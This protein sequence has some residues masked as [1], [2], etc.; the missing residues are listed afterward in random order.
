MLVQ[1]FTEIDARCDVAAAI[2]VDV[3]DELGVWARAAYGRGERLALGLAGGRLAAVVTFDVGQPAVGLDSVIIP[4]AWTAD[5]ETLFPRME[6][7]L[8]LSPMGGRCHV[9]FRGSYQPPLGG[10]GAL[11]DRVAFHRVAASTV[12]VFLE[13]LAMA[14]QA[15]SRVRTNGEAE[16][17]L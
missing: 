4:V 17:Q 11:L 6:A 12:R 9:E 1:D 14:V 8:V 15:E 5:S 7:E 2:L 3:A 10:F 16:S 13:R